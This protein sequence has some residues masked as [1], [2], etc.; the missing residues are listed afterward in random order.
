MLGK[1]VNLGGRRTAITL[2]WLLHQKGVTAPIV[3]PR[4]LEQL[5]GASLRAIELK[6]DPDTLLIADDHPI[7]RLGHPSEIAEVVCFLASPRA[8]FVTGSLML[9]DGG[10]TVI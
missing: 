10:L 6:L 7:G 4:T 1:S 5:E 2:A 9:A 8:S 3:G